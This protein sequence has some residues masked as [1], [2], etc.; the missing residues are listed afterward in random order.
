MKTPFIHHVPTDVVRNLKW[1][2]AVHRRVIKDPSYASVIW[3]ACARDPLFYVCGFG[4]TYDS[5][6]APFTKL[7]FILY[8][9]QREA[10]LKILQAITPPGSDLFVEKSRD[11][12]ASWLCILAFEWM[13]HFS[14]R[15]GAPSFIVGSRDATYVDDPENDKSLFWKIDYFH[16]YLPSWLMPSGFNRD[17]HRR[18]MKLTNPA[19]GSSITGETTTDNFA[20][21][22]RATAI[23]LDEFAAVRQGHRI[24]PSTLAA[25]KCRIFNSTPLGINNAY[26]DI[27]LTNIKKLRLHWSQHPVK[28][29]GLYT[30]ADDGS[31]KVL[32]KKG[33]P[34][35]YKPILDGKLRSPAY[36][37]EE[38]R[39][40]PREMAQE[41]DIDYLGS[42]HQYF[43]SDCIRVAIRTYSKLAIVVG[44][45]EYDNTTGDPIRFREDEN[46]HIQLWCLL[47]KDGNIRKEHKSVLGV[48]VS[49]G[50]GSSNSCLCGYDAVTNEKILEYTNP[51]IRPEEF[52]KQA[53]AIA[54]WMGGAYLVWESNGPGRQFGSRVM[55]L[56]YNNV[57]LRKREEAIGKKVSKIPGWASTR[58]TKLVL[59]GGYR[60]AVEKGMCVNR[61]KQ[62]LEE[63]LEYIFDPKGG[64]SHSRAEDK[65]DPSGARDNHGDHVIADA[66]AWRGM[67][68]R[69]NHQPISTKPVIPIGSLAWRRELRKKNQPK[70]GRELL[71]S[72]GWRW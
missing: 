54:R 48:D 36:D 66:L 22:A 40:S 1:R 27:S 15:L 16:D 62:A 65:S 21:G 25:T 69:K 6:L 33:Y 7:P 57:Y 61:S 46:G 51:Y 56:H 41:W 17:D 18:V 23:L 60:S 39:S 2:A 47:D 24:L 49:A 45:L 10:F 14:S 9:Y 42:G 32:D 4:Y 26:Y 34:E 70:P 44:N 38:S 59:L 50:T 31:L 63:C 67:T 8:P 19:N 52:A 68:E 12:G 11:T 29:R 37:Y 13:W 71:R 53:V 43:D 30:T 20:R 64:V 58:E 35:D 72:E 3:D 5:R 28:S 55:E